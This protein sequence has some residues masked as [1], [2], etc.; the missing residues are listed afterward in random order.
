MRRRRLAGRA[1]RL[2]AEVVLFQHLQ[3][4]PRARNH[5]VRQSRQPCDVDT[6]TLVCP[7]WHYFPEERHLLSIFMDSDVVI[8]RALIFAGEFHQFV[9]MCGEERLRAHPL[10]VE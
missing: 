7:T 6:V 2:N 3:N 9:V 4:L 10:F 5:G 1:V 8:L